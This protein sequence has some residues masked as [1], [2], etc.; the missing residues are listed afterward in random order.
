VSRY[1]YIAAL[2]VA[3][4][5][6]FGL[7]FHTSRFFRPT[8]LDVFGF[9]NTQLGD[10]FAVYGITAMVSY[11][12]GGA[13]AD[14]FSARF[15]L[16]ASLVATGCGGLYMA[17][18]PGARQMAVLYGFWGITTIFLFW[19]ALIR[20][21]REWGGESSQGAAF[22][23][24]EAGRGIAAA[25]FAVFLV[26]VLAA[27]LPDDATL[28]T[29]AER[30]AGMR[31]IIFAYS[32]AAFAAGAL[33]WFVIPDSGDVTS[34]RQNPL[35]NMALVMRRPVIW[36]QAAIIVCAYCGYKGVDYYS[37]YAVDVLGMDEVQ[38]ARLASYGAYV[39]PVAALAAGF[40]AD[41]F[42][43][44]RSIG[45][46]FILLAF[47]YAMLSVLLPGEAGLNAIYVN[48]FIS[49]FAVFAIRGIY[50]ALLEETRTPRH[51][52][53]AAVGMVSLLGYT[54]EIFFAPIAGRILDATPGAGGQHNL[55]L[56]LAAIATCGVLIVAWLMWLQR[57]K[58]GRD[59]VS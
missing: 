21:T 32:A 40:I 29:N 56:F 48:L 23:I 43:A 27:Y 22:G 20:A 45:V 25:V 57:N 28:A 59:A 50:F 37:L 19:G 6:I 58:S 44:T 39:R 42:G 15:L 2:V 24:L 17:T 52:T 47:V 26:A 14:R 10:L 30:R 5:M 1:L 53:G 51:V 55:F 7:P 36:A 16:T 54:P 31:A 49:L 33:A 4:E 34:T 18:I 38:G 41:R 3:G 9:T 13:I 46:A 35:R 8:L 12:P 11:F